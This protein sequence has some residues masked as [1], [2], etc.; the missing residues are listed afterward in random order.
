LINEGRNISF[1]FKGS[2]GCI[3]EKIVEISADSIYFDHKI[4]E[5]DILIE[6]GVKSGIRNCSL[7]SFRMMA[8]NN[9]NTVKAV[10]KGSVVVVIFYLAVLI[11]GL[12]FRLVLLTIK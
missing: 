2:K 9:N 4:S 11:G 8:Y 1:V 7:D 6:R 12:F 10:G 5:K 3:K